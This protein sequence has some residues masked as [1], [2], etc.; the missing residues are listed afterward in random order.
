MCIIM[1]PNCNLLEHTH[2]SK[3][4]I[5]CPFNLKKC[6]IYVLIFVSYDFYPSMTNSIF[7]AC[8][9]CGTSNQNCKDENK[10]CGTWGRK[11]FCTS[12]TYKNYMKLRCKKTCKLC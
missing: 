9:K 8:K 12:G 3:L 1:L 6:L 4:H 10:D 7:Q 2:L 11:G 5:F